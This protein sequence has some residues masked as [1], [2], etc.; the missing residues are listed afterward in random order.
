MRPILLRCCAAT[1]ACFYAY[2]VSFSVSGHTPSWPPV[3]LKYRRSWWFYYR[4]V[5]Q[6]RSRRSWSILEREKIGINYETYSNRIYSRILS[7]PSLPMAPAEHHSHAIPS[8]TSR[9]F[10]K[11]EPCKRPSSA[12]MPL[13]RNAATPSP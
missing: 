3:D 12:N 2:I 8:E 9:E 10:G 5:Y 11:A 4:R 13:R 6:V 7:N 1:N